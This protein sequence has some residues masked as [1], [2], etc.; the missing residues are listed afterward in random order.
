[1]AKGV[2]RPSPFWEIRGFRP[3]RFGH[4]RFKPMSSQTIDFKIDSCRFPRQALCII[5]MRQGLVS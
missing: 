4:R 5:S 2:E 3:R 1:M